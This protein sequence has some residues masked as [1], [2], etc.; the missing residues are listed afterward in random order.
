MLPYV[1]Q[2]ANRKT[3]EFSDRPLESKSYRII[4]LYSFYSTFPALRRNKTLYTDNFLSFPC[5]HLYGR[6]QATYIEAAHIQQIAYIVLP[7]RTLDW[8]L[9]FPAVFVEKEGEKDEEEGE[10]GPP[11]VAWREGRL[12]CSVQLTL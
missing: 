8:P 10:K 6:A 11:V 7:A 5:T 2:T 4:R 3:R 9:N 12:C 1:V